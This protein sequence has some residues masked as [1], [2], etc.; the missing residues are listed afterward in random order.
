[1]INQLKDEKFLISPMSLSVIAMAQKVTKWWCYLLK[2]SH[3]ISPTAQGVFAKIA[4]A[5]YNQ[6]V[7]FFW[8]AMLAVGHKDYRWQGP[9]CPAWLHCSDEFIPRDTFSDFFYGSNSDVFFFRG[10]S[11][12]LQNPLTFR[13]SQLVVFCCC[14]S[15]NSSGVVSAA[16]QWTS[17]SYQP[18]AQLKWFICI[19]GDYIQMPINHNLVGVT[20]V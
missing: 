8:F 12:K 15:T 11:R 18:A 10:L 6:R 13:S 19:A 2:L 9:N 17:L 4:A 3:D 5:S 20:C 7:N 1:M 14:S 16:A